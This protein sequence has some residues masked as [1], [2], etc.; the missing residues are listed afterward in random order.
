MLIIKGERLNDEN[1]IHERIKISSE[2]LAVTLYGL[3]EE[4]DCEDLDDFLDCLGNESI[5]VYI[6]KKGE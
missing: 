2:A 6:E 5:L 3:Y 1:N 4:N